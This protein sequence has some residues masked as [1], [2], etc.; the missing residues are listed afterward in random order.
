M[1]IQ[2]ARDD[3]TQMVIVT[4]NGELPSVHDIR[5]VFHRHR[6][7]NVWHYGTLYDLRSMTGRPS[8]NY[9]RDLIA[10]A[11]SFVPGGRTRGPVALLASEPALHEIAAAFVEFE[12][13]KSKIQVFREIA[14][15]KAWLRKE[16]GGSTA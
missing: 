7:E 6:A 5:E 4:L 8:F 14:P 2:Y 15:A 16:P 1:P 10:N 13:A 9:L 12:R 11:A 3:G